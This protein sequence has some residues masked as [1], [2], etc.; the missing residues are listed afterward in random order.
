MAT[1]TLSA[2]EILKQNRLLNFS[3][4]YS[5]FDWMKHQHIKMSQL[6]SIASETA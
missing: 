2:D 6:L 3:A 1:R 4:N 5:W